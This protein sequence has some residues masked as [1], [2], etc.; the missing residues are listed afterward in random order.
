MEDYTSSALSDIMLYAVKDRE[1]LKRM[2]EY[3][4]YLNDTKYSWTD[5]GIK[6]AE[7]YRSL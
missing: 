7:V 1:K 3:A 6:T 5:I 2:G 4:R